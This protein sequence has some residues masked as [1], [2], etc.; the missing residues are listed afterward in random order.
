[1]II[2]WFWTFITFSVISKSNASRNHSILCGD[3][4]KRIFSHFPT[5]NKSR[6]RLVDSHFA[7]CINGSINGHVI[8]SLRSLA[9]IH[10][11]DTKQMDQ[12]RLFNT[13]YE[14]NELWL[15]N[16][17]KI[18]KGNRYLSLLSIN[19]SNSII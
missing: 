8:A 17:L 16:Y 1:M 13:K 19:G 15:L 14:F 7:Q 10:P 18:M 2:M 11:N 6:L 5:T 3:V 4:C 12:L 9:T